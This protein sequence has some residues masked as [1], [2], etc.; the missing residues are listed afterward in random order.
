MLVD[1]ANIGCGYL[2][3]TLLHPEEYGIGNLTAPFIQAYFD[4]M[5][6]HEDWGKL[7]WNMDYEVLLGTH[8]IDRDSIGDYKRFYWRLVRDSIGDSMLHLVRASVTRVPL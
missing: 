6:N 7:G 8:I 2:K 1:P 3:N 4:Y 5:W